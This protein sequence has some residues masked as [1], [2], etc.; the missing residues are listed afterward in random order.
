M[1]YT[2][3]G[4]RAARQR[5]VGALSG[6]ERIEHEARP[7]LAEKNLLAIG[8]VSTGFV[9][10]LLARCRGQEYRSSPHDSD[11]ATEVHIFTPIDSM[12]R[13]WYIKLYFRGHTV[14]ISV[15]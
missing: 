5:A 1:G 8:D 6:G 14:I 4:F 7:G 9:A 15:H 3:L 10:E 11:S 12:G 13:R 2:P